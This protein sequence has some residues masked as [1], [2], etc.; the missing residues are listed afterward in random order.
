MYA[1]IAGSEVGCRKVKG[2]AVGKCK[3]RTERPEINVSRKTPFR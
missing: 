3:E 2:R 1:T